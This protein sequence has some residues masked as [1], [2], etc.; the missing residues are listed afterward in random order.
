M[1][2][3]RFALVAAAALAF[4]AA[5]CVIATRDP[6]GQPC[7]TDAD[8]DAPQ[9]HDQAGAIYRCSPDSDGGGEKRCFVV[10]PPGAPADTGVDAGPSRIVYW[11]NE[12]EP[13]MQTYCAVCHGEDRTGGLNL[14]F[15]A[16]VYDDIDG[17][18]L[19]GGLDGAKTKAD[20]FKLRVFDQRTMP[21]FGSAMPTD[22]ERVAI[23]DWV[24]SGAPFCVDGGM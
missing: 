19:N 22:A 4:G 9:L 21:P 17:G 5:G 14:P 10:F 23:K 1:P 18:S 8:C 16:D 24:L 3:T 11:C 12:I 13:L 15:R 20:K 2:R 7:Q 6:A